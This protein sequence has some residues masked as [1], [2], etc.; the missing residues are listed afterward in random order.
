M[1]YGEHRDSGG[2]TGASSQI[3]TPSLW[4]LPRVFRQAMVRPGCKDRGA[5]QP[6]SR[7]AGSFEH[8]RPSPFVSSSEELGLR[9]ELR[10]G[11]WFGSPGTS[12]RRKNA[13]GEQL[14]SP[15]TRSPSNHFLLRLRSFRRL[16]FDSRMTGSFEDLTP[17]RSAPF[18]EG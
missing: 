8:P 5:T 9:S 12:K 4:S 7:M 3:S 1:A 17:P 2:L 6:T 18:P 15:S 14:S 11:C 13:Y 16:A 10:L